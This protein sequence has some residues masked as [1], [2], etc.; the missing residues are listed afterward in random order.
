MLFFRLEPVDPEAC[1]NVFICREMWPDEFSE[2]LYF[3]LANMCLCY[4]IPLCIITAC[5]MAI[6]LKVWRRNIPG[7]QPKGLALELAMQRSKLKV[8]KMM[9]VVV[10]IF[11]LSWLPLYCIFAR[12]KLGPPL[13]SGSL[14]ERIL[15]TTAPIAQWLGA[16]NSCINPIL[17]A[18]FNKKYRKGFAAI[19]KSR[20]CCGQIGPNGVRY[21][22]PR[23]RQATMNTAYSTY[24]QTTQRS[25]AANN[26]TNLLTTK[27]VESNGHLTHNNNG[28][29]AEL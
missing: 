13:E 25:I 12:V 19:I 27:L 6:W 23:G 17:Y 29:T 2:R 1:P 11:V 26:R 18:F 3:M 15:M 14:E 20:S 21:G 16:S 4:L 24:R 9:I 7:E 10:V 22:D 5:Y 28:A 8:A